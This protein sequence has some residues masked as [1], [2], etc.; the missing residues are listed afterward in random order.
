[1]RTRAGSWMKRSTA[2]PNRC[3]SLWSFASF[4]AYPGATRPPGS[5]CARAQLAQLGEGDVLRTLYYELE[6]DWYMERMMANA[7]IKAL[8][9]KDLNSFGGYDWREG[10]TVVG[11][12]LVG[13]FDP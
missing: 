7:G 13:T 1:M 8:S 5:A 4:K 3:G 10:A 6:S 9:G 12:E 2:C 11:R